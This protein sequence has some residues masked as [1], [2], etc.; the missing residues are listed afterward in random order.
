MKVDYYNRQGDTIVFEKLDNN[1]VKMSGYQYSRSGFNEDGSKIEFI[2][3]A[4]GPYIGVGMNLNTYFN[5]KKNMIIKAIEF[6]PE[7]G[8]VLKI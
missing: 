5:T 6:E 4:G 8:L 2:D 1:T 7:N 3:P